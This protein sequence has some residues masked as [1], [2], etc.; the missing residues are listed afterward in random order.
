[1]TYRVNRKGFRELFVDTDSL[2]DA[3]AMVKEEEKAGRSMEIRVK[4]KTRFCT[5]YKTEN[6]RR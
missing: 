3:L 4:Q 5:I 6:N 1:M 2:K